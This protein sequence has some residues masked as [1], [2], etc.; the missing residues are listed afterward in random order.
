[1]L[2]V[3]HQGAGTKEQK[4]SQY[5][6]SNHKKSSEL[7]IYIK[8]FHWKQ[9]TTFKSQIIILNEDSSLT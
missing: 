1:M 9:N 8:N 2:V 6:I 5:G 3:S 7:L 4:F